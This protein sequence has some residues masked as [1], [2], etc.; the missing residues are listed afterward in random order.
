M[1]RVGPEFCSARAVRVGII[2]LR[3]YETRRL[4]P[5]HSISRRVTRRE[6][7]M[8]KQFIYFLIEE[9]DSFEEMNDEFEASTTL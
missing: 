6:F 2:G 3:D 1:A 7:F 5:R 9:M 8:K 4:L